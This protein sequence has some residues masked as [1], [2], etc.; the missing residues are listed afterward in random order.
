MTIYAENFKRYITDNAR[1]KI[2]FKQEEIDRIIAI[3]K[4]SPT[5]L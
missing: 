3:T 1:D 2:G 4:R 5:R